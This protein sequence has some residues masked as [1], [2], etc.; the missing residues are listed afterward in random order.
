M[1]NNFYVEYEYEEEDV[2]MG[3]L[4]GDDDDYGSC[5][6]GGG[7]SYKPPVRKVVKVVKAPTKTVNYNQIIA[8]QNFAGFWSV[9]DIHLLQPYYGSIADA[10]R[11]DPMVT[12][13]IIQV[14]NTQFPQLRN[15]WYLIE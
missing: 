5:G 11:S 1:Y 3:G 2:D 7:Y 9:S 10:D 12:L 4:F 8:R 6:G 13:L 15:E 14:L